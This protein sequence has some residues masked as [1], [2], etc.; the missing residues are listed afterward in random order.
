MKYMQ[1]TVEKSFLNQNFYGI[2]VFN[3]KALLFPISL[4]DFFF[5]FSY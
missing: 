5:F 1:K 2:Y 4:W 3:L